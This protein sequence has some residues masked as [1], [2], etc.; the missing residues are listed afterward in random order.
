MRQHV[1]RTTG[2]LWIDDRWVAR[3]RPLSTALNH[4][5]VSEST[6][7]RMTAEANKWSATNAVVRLQI[8]H[9]PICHKDT[10][11]R[12]DFIKTKFCTDSF[13]NKVDEVKRTENATPLHVILAY[14]ILI[15]LTTASLSHTLPYHTP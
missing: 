8:V 4:P 7:K 10:I 11:K 2:K 3:L 15:Y 5:V 14:L 9:I 6:S 1:A 12:Q 13:Q